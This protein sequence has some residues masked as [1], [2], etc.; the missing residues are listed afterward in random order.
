MQRTFVDFLTSF[1]A[2]R[3][4]DQLQAEGRIR[5]LPT[6][7][8]AAGLGVLDKLMAQEFID[9]DNSGATLVRLL[10]GEIKDDGNRE[11]H[12][13]DTALLGK[14]SCVCEPLCQAAS[15]RL[16]AQAGSV[17]GALKEIAAF[18]RRGDGRSSDCWA[19][20]VPGGVHHIGADPIDFSNINLT[21]K[22][23]PLGMIDGKPCVL[24]GARRKHSYRFNRLADGSVDG[25]SVQSAR[26][27]L[28]FRLAQYRVQDVV[29]DGV[30]I[31]A[32]SGHYVA[33]RHQVPV[34]FDDDGEVFFDGAVK[35][36]AEMDP[37]WGH[38]K[39]KV[40]V[41]RCTFCVNNGEDDEGEVQARAA[42]LSALKADVATLERAMENDRW[43]NDLHMTNNPVIEGR[44]EYNNSKVEKVCGGAI[45]VGALT[46][47]EIDSSQFRGN[48]S[49]SGGAIYVAGL[50]MSWPELV[51]SNEG[52]R[53]QLICRNSQFASN[54]A[55]QAAG[56]AICIMERA[57]CELVNCDF[58]RNI[59]GPHDDQCGLDNCFEFTG[60]GAVYVSQHATLSAQ[61]C[62]FT[63]NRAQIEYQGGGA[64]CAVA[65]SSVS[66][67]GCHFTQNGAS[68]GGAVCALAASNRGF[69]RRRGALPMQRD[70]A[71]RDT[72]GDE[73]YVHCPS[74][75]DE[76]DRP[77]WYP[78]PTEESR[79]HDPT[80][81][82][83]YWIGKCKH[84]P[85]HRAYIV[86]QA[87]CLRVSKCTFSG[88]CAG[89]FGSKMSYPTSCELS[90]G[91]G[92][93]FADGVPVQLTSSHLSNNKA[94]NGTYGGAIRTTANA[95]QP[96]SCEE[97]QFAF[98]T[99]GLGGAV[100]TTT[101][102]VLAMRECLFMENMSE[103][104]GAAADAV[105]SMGL[106]GQRLSVKNGMV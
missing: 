76:E 65:A 8:H 73:R 23:D 64:I 21:I 16:I 87:G 19:F 61:N 48:T 79:R 11:N 74:S 82:T 102:S 44:P 18:A 78:E 60:G 103:Q 93:I 6:D 81:S 63:R 37:G 105:F 17:A 24:Q 97:C 14:L 91:G 106:D 47:V 36:Q 13:L 59:C 101:D 42:Y 27:S 104:E 29:L 84:A 69:L 53:A 77:D 30:A 89:E 68:T 88:N 67:E 26:A 9:R 5:V 90:G 52:N 31:E 66:V 34:L 49:L 56:G 55:L 92:A 7:T 40:Y 83:C 86:E 71:Y 57:D 95:A 1:V 54:H 70:L 72:S 12:E 51:R 15:D 3:S 100:L 10:E 33:G 94:E 39:T 2:S 50:D 28:R 43:S 46:T 38:P 62:S 96:L 75:E 32:F 45:I 99:A 80:C 25:A 22:G 41:S 20:R 85:P 58:S 4:V 35:G 98:N